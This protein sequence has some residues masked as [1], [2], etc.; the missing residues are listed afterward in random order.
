MVGNELNQEGKIS[1]RSFLSQK[2]VERATDV[3]VGNR[4]KAGKTAPE[5]KD[6]N[7]V[8]RLALELYFPNIESHTLVGGFEDEEKY[9]GIVVGYSPKELVGLN[10]A[11]KNLATRLYKLGIAKRMNSNPHVVPGDPEKAKKTPRINWSDEG[12]RNLERSFDEILME[13]PE[14]SLPDSD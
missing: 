14:Y 8:Q 6:V 7:T 10:M 12:R 3:W 5:E 2:D 1:L 9:Q 4:L 11:A 13:D